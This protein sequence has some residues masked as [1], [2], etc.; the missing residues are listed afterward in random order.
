MQ[1][2]K[3]SSSRIPLLEIRISRHPHPITL[4]ISILV[5]RINS[6]SGRT[7]PSIDTKPNHHLIKMAT[8]QMA[9]AVS[10]IGKAAVF[11]TSEEEITRII[12][13]KQNYYIVLKVLKD[14]DQAEIRQ[15]HKK[16][17]LLCHPDKN[18]SNPNAPDAS[19]ILNQ[20]KDT[21]TNPMKKQLYD[22]YVAD[23]A[24]AGS[25]KDEMSYAEWE[26]AQ[27]AYPVR[28]PA[29]VEKLL[30]MPVLG[31]IIALLMLILLIP[32]VLIAIALGIVLYIICLPINIIVRCC[33]GVPPPPGGDPSHQPGGSGDGATSAP[34]QQTTP[35][36]T[37][38]A[39]AA[40]V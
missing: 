33:C 29:W 24:A 11:G 15:N 21:L 10:N 27:A 1:L 23:V 13:Y 12:A 7:S 36:R 34:E 9:R 22:I 28:L 37:A 40:N 2:L 31:Q 39:A 26:A 14:T 17:S 30:R 5:R 32:L 19:A 4:F 18:P 6:A 20:A 8:P 38:D 35:S 3:I 25:G 16:L